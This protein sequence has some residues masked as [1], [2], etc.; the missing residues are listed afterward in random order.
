MI[1]RVMLLLLLCSSL[2]GQSFNAAPF[3]GVGNT[4][5]A[6][7]SLYSITNNAA[8]LASLKSTEA[9]VAYQPNFLS[10]EI[11]T[12]ALYVGLPIQPMGA[13]GI[14]IH[15]YGLAGVSSLLTLS[16]VYARSFADIFS[17]SLT[18]GYHS[19]SVKNY[20]RT[21]TFSVDLGFQVSVTEELDIGAVFRN[22]SKEMFADDVDQ[23]LPREIGVGA[24]YDVSNSIYLVSDVYYDAFQRFNVRGGVSYELDKMFVI[25][26]GVSSGEVQYYAGLGLNVGKM[27]IDCS[28]SFHSYLGT[29]PQ[30]AFRYVF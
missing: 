4:G 26:A 27:M 13:F 23:Y 14:G 24:K 5:I 7:K 19:F 12:Q 9:A 6:L 10:S 29:S 15:R 16:G 30:I 25:R 8:G 1:Y 20:G 11:S 3:Q 28:S 18:V 17:T 22:I 21:Q 2:Y